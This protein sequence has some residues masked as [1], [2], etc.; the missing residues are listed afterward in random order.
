MN[1]ILLYIYLISFCAAC[2][3]AE[4]NDKVKHKDDDDVPK[5]VKLAFEKKYPDERSP[6]WGVDRNG[7]FEAAFK[8]D[9][10]KY[11][12]DFTPS[13]E[14]IET[15]NNIKEK[16]LP[17]VIRQII[18]E[19][20]QDYKIVELERVA[21]AKKGFF[22]DVEFKKDGKKMDVEFNEQGEVIGVEE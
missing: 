18:K 21:H 3:S 7:N 9:G 15:E 20:F 8:D 12:A 1:K 19:Q 16:E 13:G 14:W 10:E 17:E 22:Y 4:L 6:K 11:R 2:N 5:I